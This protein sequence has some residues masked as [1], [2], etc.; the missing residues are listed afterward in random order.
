MELESGKNLGKLES[1]LAV[2]DWDTLKKYSREYDAYL[3]G[4]ERAGNQPAGL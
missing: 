4:G 3:R 1:A 2:K